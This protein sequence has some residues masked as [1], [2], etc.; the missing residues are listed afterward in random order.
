MRKNIYLIAATLFSVLFQSQTYTYQWAKTGGATNGYPTVGFTQSMDEHI[1]DIAVDNQNNSY[2][3]TSMYDSNPLLDGQ[4]VSNYGSKDIV[5]FSTD[6]QGNVRWKR[7]IGGGGNMTENAQ[8][9]VL[10]NNGGLYLTFGVGNGSSVSSS[11]YLPPRFGDN[12][13]LPLVSNNFMD[14]QEALRSGFLLKYNS[15]DGNL[16]WRKD[17]QGDVSALNSAIDFSP[18]IM[19]SQNNIHV[20][21]G[22]LNGN[23]LNGMVTVPS[24]YNSSLNFQY[25]LVKYDTNG[26]IVG[27]PSL[28][29]FSGTT[30]F[31]VGYLSFMYD[32]VNSR[33]YVAGSRN[34]EGSGTNGNALS[35]NNVPINGSGFLLAFNSTTFVELWR[36]EQTVNNPIGAMFLTGLKKDPTT[37]DI[38]ISGKFGTVN[39]TVSFGGD[40]T[41]STPLNG[42]ISFVMKL[43]TTNT[44]SNVIWCTYPTSLSDGSTQVAMEN[45]RMPIA[46]K[47]NEVLFAKGSIRE[48]WGNYPMIRPANDRTDPLL[49]R[50][51]KDTGVVNGTYE[52]QGS[53]GQED[54]FT[55]VAVDNDNNI[56]LGGFIHQQ[57][58]TA[59]NDNIATI[60]NAAGSTKSDF[61]FAKLA[62][63]A[64]CSS[65]SVE[66]TAVEAG[67]QFYPNPVLDNLT[68]KS[69]NKLESYEVYSSAGQT[70]LR[71]GLGSTNTQINMSALTAG[72]YYVKVK[73]EKAVVTEK[74]LKK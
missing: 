43:G 58:F 16:V 57:L 69:K 41:F 10:D 40:Y 32:E 47:G 4:P 66:E 31:K 20:I 3:I 29:P 48:V 68:I 70:V 23:H 35:Y 21:V 46:I 44:S 45:A 36:R 52:I 71:G 74:I 14:P 13:V 38:Y 17:F 19:D 1:L 72:V 28:L 50:F 49:V 12:N 7:T 54:H 30:T 5:L 64:T 62:T 63:S 33:Y 65:L 53:Y 67:L 51:N 25:Y 2:Y 55:A 18:P 39:N 11:Q 61:F 56:M 73:T 26:N 42:P 37:S 22:L 8:K 60:S 15:A 6:C 59:A 24:S 34:T 9:I 27:T